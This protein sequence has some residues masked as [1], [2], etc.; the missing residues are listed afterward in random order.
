MKPQ[1]ENSGPVRLSPEAQLFLSALLDEWQAG[2]VAV[3][4]KEKTAQDSYGTELSVGDVRAAANKLNLLNR[5][6][7]IARLDRRRLYARA[8]VGALVLTAT[9]ASLLGVYY[10][11]RRFGLDR[12]DNVASI[13]AAFFSLVALVGSLWAAVVARKSLKETLDS[14]PIIEALDEAKFLRGWAELEEA[15]RS[16]V[17]AEHGPHYATKPFRSLLQEYAVS[18]GLSDDQ[19]EELRMLLQLRNRAA[20]SSVGAS[21]RDD[22]SSAWTALSRQLLRASKSRSS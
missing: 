2:V 3:A 9:T 10:L 1:N 13:S 19:V 15:I 18:E 5:D 16:R 14:P 22:L 7:A 4:L 21:D 20:H 12:A 11:A 8:A 6:A 17:V